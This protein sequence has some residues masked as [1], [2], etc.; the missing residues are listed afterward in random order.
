[1]FKQQLLLSH[2]LTEGQHLVV[3]LSNNS[4]LYVNGEELEMADRRYQI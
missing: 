1:M 4:P 3:V 2:I